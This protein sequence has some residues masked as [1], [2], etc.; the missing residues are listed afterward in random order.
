MGDELDISR[1]GALAVDTEQLRGVGRR[2]R[3]L[4]ERLARVAGELRLVRTLADGAGA[5]AS[6]LEGPAQ[7][8]AG[9]AELL[10]PT[11]QGVELMAEAYEIVELRARAELRAASDPGEAAA[12]RRDAELLSERNPAAAAAAA[13]LLAQGERRRFDGFVDQTRW[14]QY[15]SP[16]GAHSAQLAAGLWLTGVGMVGKGVRLADRPLHPSD[17]SVVIAPTRVPGPS[18][19]PRGL[20]DLTDRFPA[21]PG[22][23]V[24]VET[25]T[26]PDGRREYIAYVAGTQLSADSREPWGMGA[27][28]DLYLHDRETA[29]YQAVVDALHDAGAGEGDAVAIVGHSQGAMIGG[30]VAQSGEFPVHTLV[31]FGSPID[32]V[33]PESTTS[34]M[35]RHTDDPVSS[36]AQGG[37]VAG[38]GSSDSVVVSRIGD[39]AQGLQDAVLT[40]HHLSTYA[41]TA[42]LADAAGDPRLTALGERLAALDEAAEILATD[43]VARIEPPTR[44]LAPGADAPADDRF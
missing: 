5:D 14:A 30:L 20:A 17:T 9:V 44:V 10:V 23:Q 40:T 35:V 12:L 28:L 27:N 15:L 8:I 3:A 13:S 24:R 36:L 33:L 42:A 22:A 29:S 6:G 1:G 2:L 39:P 31:G 11:A 18:A 25:Y 19:A 26:M 4:G 7:R 38:T 16:A 34:V 41:E 21:T 37:T 32:P 43:Y